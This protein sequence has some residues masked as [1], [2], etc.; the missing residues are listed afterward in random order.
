[1]SVCHGLPHENAVTAKHL[2]DIDMLDIGLLA[3]IGQNNTLL[4]GGMEMIE[5]PGAQR[6][7]ESLDREKVGETESWKVVAAQGG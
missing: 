7:I 5:R 2:F 6:L 4:I 3:V 1:M